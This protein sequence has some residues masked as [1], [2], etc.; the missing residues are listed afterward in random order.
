MNYN[1]W[2]SSF[3]D[4][5]LQKIIQTI[6]WNEFFAIK[7][8]V[9][10]MLNSGMINKKS[11]W[12]LYQISF[13]KSVKR[14]DVSF[15]QIFFLWKRIK[16]FLEVENNKLKRYLYKYMLLLTFRLPESLC[17]GSTPDMNFV[18]SWYVIEDSNLATFKGPF[19]GSNPGSLKVNN[20]IF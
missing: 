7:N 3:I 4:H 20:V 16:M 12:P 2:V 9:L 17:I 11:V 13:T 1:I 19:K 6:I 15:L 14:N 10:I 18:Y 8:K 5:I